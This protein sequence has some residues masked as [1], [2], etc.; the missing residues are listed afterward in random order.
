MHKVIAFVLP[1]IYLLWLTAGF[2]LP[3]YALSDP[4]QI[5]DV[6]GILEAIIRIL[7][8]VAGIAFL[9]MVLFGGFKF[10][11][12]GGDQKAVAQ[13]KAIL[14]YAVI[15]VILVV[16]SWLILTLIRNITGVEV[17]KVEFPS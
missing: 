4:A 2:L 8:P 6:V 17:T 3:V 1:G 10:V 11:T 14:T 9:I 13:A 15:G 12:S 5:S 16:I 7:P